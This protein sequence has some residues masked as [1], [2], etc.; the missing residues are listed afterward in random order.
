MPW[1]ELLRAS[2]SRLLRR[3]VASLLLLQG[4]VWGVAVAIFPAAVL[5]G[6]RQSALTRGAAVGA[7]RLALVADPTA[8]PRTPLTVADLTRVERALAGLGS[9]PPPVAGVRRLGSGRARPDAP[10]VTLLAGTP[11]T[12]EARGLTLA[13]GRWPGPDDPPGACVVEARVAEALG[14]PALGPGDALRLPGHPE[15]LL[16][17]GVARARDPALLRTDDLG[18]DTGHGLYESVARPFLLAMGVPSVRDGW[19]RSDACVY[20]ALGDA[21]E[22]DW[23]LAR[24]DPPLVLRGAEAARDALGAAGR[25]V[26]A[27]HP[28]VLPVLLGDE[29]DR[30]GRVSWAMFLACLVMGAVVI[31][32]VGLL[33]VLERTRELALRRVEG[34]TRPGV[35]AQILVEGGVLAVV[36]SLLGFALGAGLAELR[37]RL[38]PVHGFDWVFPTG[39]A[40]AAALVALGVGLLAALLPAWRAVRLDPVEG[41]ADE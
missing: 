31:A 19:K 32:H 2:V 7:G 36:G 15:P 10:E 40:L 21:G 25:A 26:V 16:V 27:L 37:V 6:T 18:F 30:F 1:T 9:A 12:L 14:R 24:L 28:L 41:L 23:I 11:R 3:P 38:E 33:S 8:A 20:V 17:V 34:A 39:H 13:A 5:E 4:T 22:L 35:A 29:V